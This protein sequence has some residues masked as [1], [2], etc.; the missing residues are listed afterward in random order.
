MS[1]EVPSGSDGRRRGAGCIVFP[2]LILVVWWLI[3]TYCMG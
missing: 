3:R 1:D 2:P